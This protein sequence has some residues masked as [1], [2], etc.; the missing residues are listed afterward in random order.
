L[1]FCEGAGAGGREKGFGEKRYQE[2]ATEG[3]AARF[4]GVW[5]GVN[6]VTCHQAKVKGC[7]GKLTICTRKHKGCLWNRA[8]RREIIHP[9]ESIRISKP[10]EGRRRKGK[11]K[12]EGGGATAANKKKRGCRAVEMKEKSFRTEGEDRQRNS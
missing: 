6:C 3:E 2:K 11:K 4:L 10:T 9:S 1:A 12:A 8:G 5:V 7:E